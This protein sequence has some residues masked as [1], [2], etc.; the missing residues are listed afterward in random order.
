MR[1]VLFACALAPAAIHAAGLDHSIPLQA[2]SPSV[3]LMSPAEHEK[4]ALQLEH[5]R[6]RNEAARLQLEA[7]R[8]QLAND[9][10]QYK[11]AYLQGWNDAAAQLQD[12][13]S[14]QLA[15]AGA[16]AEMVAGLNQKQLATLQGSVASR[17]EKEP[18]NLGLWALL[19]MIQARL[20]VIGK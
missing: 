20:D 17:Y 8:S 12:D 18:T 4:N 13:H 1:F 5:M 15:A 6:Q 3:R 11:Q 10:S 7:R 19:C 16:M 9:A 2:L 14:F